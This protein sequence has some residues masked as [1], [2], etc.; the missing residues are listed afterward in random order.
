MESVYTTHRRSRW[1]SQKVKI[2]QQKVYAYVR[3]KSFYKRKYD[4]RPIRIDITWVSKKF[5]IS[6]SQAR[7]CMANLV[8]EGAVDKWT[9]YWRP[10]RNCTY[11][12]LATLRK[13]ENVDKT[14]DKSVDNFISQMR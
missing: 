7:R 10:R 5:K 9:V 3:K 11:Y 1:K 2:L 8:S 6:Y 12:R 4:T 14:V 13:K